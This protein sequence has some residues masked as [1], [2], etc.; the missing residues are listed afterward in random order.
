MKK[1]VLFLNASILLCLTAS[2]QIAN[3]EI[4][5]GDLQIL[6]TS[7]LGHAP[8]S[9]FTAAVDPNSFYSNISG[10]TGNGITNGGAATQNITT[11]AGTVS[12]LITT[13]VADSLGFIGTGPYSVASWSFSVA[14]FNLVD[15]SVRARVRFYK[16]DGVSGR[17]GTYIT[18]FSFNP[19]V[20]AA[21]NIT[22][23]ST[24]TI[25]SFPAGTTAVWAGI[26]FDNVNAAGTGTTGAT[27]AQMNNMGQG[28]STPI[29]RGSSTVT[30]FGT[31]LPGSFALVN[32]PVGGDYIVTTTAT[33]AI[34]PQNF[35]WQL[36]AP[37]ATVPVTIEYLHGAKTAGG[38]TL[39][40]KL[41]CPDGDNAVM[42]LQR[43]TDGRNF[44]SV[45]DLTANAARCAQEFNYNDSR[46]ISGINYY[47]IKIVNADGRATYSNIVTLTDKKATFTLVN[48]QPNPTSD[49]L[50]LNIAGA[51]NDKVQITVQD[52][53][54]RRVLTQT[55]QITAGSNPI[56][57]DVSK[58]QAGTYTITGISSAVDGIRESIS[59]IKK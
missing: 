42:T 22:T 4:P 33:G 53:N 49:R 41:G 58:L 11:S 59:F 27:L 2:A 28:V 13:L 39:A 31:D 43:S 15:V 48:V 24:T 55:A 36:V 29:D 52:M 25:F 21:N 14:N 37:V 46:A 38:N 20:Y 40:W 47:R 34:V 19:L 10:Y 57:V 32:N 26:T 18:G 1:F 23:V 8:T 30:F 17:P 3:R 9:H 50:V 56:T 12:G 16:T 45:Y 5:A 7:P 54:G 6:A 44:S 35:G 51:Q